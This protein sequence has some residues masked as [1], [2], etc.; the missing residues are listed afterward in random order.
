MPCQVPSANRPLLIGS[1]SD[2][3]SSDALMCAGMS[4]LPSSVCVHSVLRS[5]T[6]SLNHDSKSLRTSALA[7]SFSVSDADVW[8]ISTC[9]RP[10]ATSPSSGTPASTSRVIKWNPRRRGSRISSRWSHMHASL[11]SA[12]TV[13]QPA[14]D[15]IARPV[16]HTHVAKQ[17]RA[18]VR[19]KTQRIDLKC[20]IRCTIRLRQRRLVLELAQPTGHA[21]AHRVADLARTVVELRRS[22][23]PETAAREHLAFQEAQVTIAIC[24][25]ARIALLLCL[26]RSNNLH[27]E[28]QRRRGDRRQ[29]Q[30][31]L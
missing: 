4:S 24:A 8:R 26:R 9:N 17:P 18:R 6:V 2:G 12:V 30:L 28:A 19:T 29:L 1:V 5:G 21:S 27:R 23:G 15:R 11:S 20:Q 31:L 25:Q 14:L 13:A 7:F 10:T 22:S 3:P 16:E